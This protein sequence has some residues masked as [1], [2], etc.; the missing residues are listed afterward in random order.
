MQSFDQHY[1]LFI[2]KNAIFSIFVVKEGN[3]LTNELVNKITSSLEAA[4]SVVYASAC[5]MAERLLARHMLMYAP[6]ADI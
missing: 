2:L 4:E 3:L 5:S 6:H 1:H